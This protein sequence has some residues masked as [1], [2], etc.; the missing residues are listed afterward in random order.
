MYG[1]P[2]R[3]A[4][5]EGPDSGDKNPHFVRSSTSSRLL[6]LLTAVFA[7]LAAIGVMHL[8]SMHPHVPLFYANGGDELIVLTWTK[9]LIDDGWYTTISHLGA[10]YGMS[11]GD[12]PVPN[13]LHL[14]ILRAITLVIPN[15]GLAVNL[16]Y[17]AGFPLIA[18]ACAYVLRRLRVSWPV[19][20]A[21]SVVYAMLPFRFLRN[22]AHLYYAQYYLT[23]ILVL[24]VIWVWRDQPLFDAG[25]RRPTR[26]G[27]IFLAGLLAISWDNEYSAVFA[28]LFL[29]LAAVAS[30]VRTRA[31]RG[32]IAAVAGILIVFVGVE[33]ELLPTT[34]YQRQHGSDAAAIVRPAQASEIYAL[35]FAQLVLPIEGHRVAFLARRRARFDSGMPEL[36]NESSSATLGVLGALGFVGSLAALLILRLREDELWPDL[37]RLN[38]AAFLLATIG[39]VGAIISYYFVP[40]L[41]AYNR[42]SPLIAFVS[43]AAVATALEIIRQRWF[44]RRSNDAVW[45]GILVVVAILAILDQTSSSYVPAYGAD[46]QAYIG[47]V[48]FAATLEQRLP[49]NAALYQIPHV[50]F[51]EGPLVEQLGSWDQTAL[52]LHSTTLRYSFGATRGREADAWQQNT[53][54]LPVHSFIEQLVMAGFDGILVYRTG[55]ADRGVAEETA[56]TAQLGASPLVSPNGNVSFYD[57]SKIRAAFIA[58]AGVAAA[59]TVRDTVLN[60]RVNVALGDGFYATEPCGTETCNWGQKTATLVINNAAVTPIPVTLDVLATTAR[61][62]TAS[63][64]LAG[65]AGAMKR[66]AIDAA[67]KNITL[68]FVAPPGTSQVELTTDARPRPASGDEPDRRFR[69][70]DWNVR[71]A[72]VAAAAAQMNALLSPVTASISANITLGFGA[73]CYG[74]ETANGSAWH[75][76]GNT[77]ELTLRNDSGETYAA[78]L[79]YSLT[80]AQPSSVSVRLGK[81]LSVYRSLPQGNAVQQPIVIPPGQTTLQF[82]TTAQP[83]VA[84]SDPRRLVLQISNFRIV[85]PHKTAGGP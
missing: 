41:R 40:E 55:Y 38:L 80:T 72:S 62:Q 19:T 66:A 3:A 1:G 24:A 14:I 46:Q 73:G 34:I 74:P 60:S 81:R 16:Y 13:L 56:L 15:A 8:W 82:G 25:R 36:A 45:R 48:A 7:S 58:R 54:A 85:E 10:P 30:Y 22:E 17:L 37:A 33:V 47:D 21:I 51:P 20:M 23:P 65:P 27:Y 63:L 52:Y 84:P 6:Y 35:R 2:A 69:L 29:A 64:N 26:D 57:L 67:G 9:A 78:Q 28:M 12:F 71:A 44:S 83:V 61:P 75:W 77:G 43:L 4:S 42:I 68:Q 53:E 32:V 31:W 76:C 59:A 79:Q 5:S 49:P 70:L 50:L 11:F 39:G 18:L